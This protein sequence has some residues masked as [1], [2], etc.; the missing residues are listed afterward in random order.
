M[1]SAAQ[2]AGLASAVA[3]PLRAGRETL[4]VLVLMSR[5]SSASPPPFDARQTETLSV[6]GEQIGQFTFRRRVE[7]D[8]ESLASLVQ[9]SSDFV[10]IASLAGDWMFINP[11][12]QRLVGL[13]GDA[14][15]RASPMRTLL[16]ED[17]TPAVLE[18]GYWSGDAHLRHTRTGAVVP[19]LQH[20]FT[21]TALDRPVALAV[22]GRDLTDIER[23]NE[24]LRRNETYLAEAQR[25]SQTGSWALKVPSGRDVFERSVHPND[26][27]RV[28]QTLDRAIEERTGLDITYRIVRPDGSVRH[29]QSVGRP[30]LNATGEVEELVGVVMDVTD[31]KRAARAL[32]RARERA[33][34][35]RFAAMLDE[36]ARVARE[37]H[38][39][40]LQGVT[41]IAL[42]LRAMLP[43]VTPADTLHRIVELA[44]RTSH[45]ARRAI[46]DLRSPSVADDITGALEDAARRHLA[47]TSLAYRLTVTGRPRALSPS[48]IPVAVRIMEEGLTNVVKHAGATS[49]WLTVA[50]ERRLV[51]ITLADDG[52]G[53]DVAGAR[54]GHWGIVGMQERADEIGGRLRLRSAPESGTEV[55][56]AIPINPRGELSRA[57]ERP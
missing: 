5:A 46:W 7:Q 57:G 40:L 25:L 9:N 54:E 56:L 21:I 39:S 22:I 18:H 34:T 12:G 52:H 33:L 28:M 45:E 23:Q 15:V 13:D 36:R 19:V 24:Q 11:A 53:F 49:I 41:G 14:D 29:A 2:L 26:R 48:V 38:D 35:A 1:A 27:E 8:R 51:R 16:V 10:G 42:Q 20:I 3:V 30:I 44:D 47:G 17:V 55:V 6:L 50:Y 4:G 43:H 37:I 31:R 32:R